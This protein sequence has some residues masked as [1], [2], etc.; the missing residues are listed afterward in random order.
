[1]LMK[2]RPLG[3][4]LR[5]KRN[6]MGVVIGIMAINYGTMAA[7]AGP[8]IDQNGKQALTDMMVSTTEGYWND[9]IAGRVVDWLNTVDPA[10]YGLGLTNTDNGAIEYNGLNYGQLNQWLVSSEASGYDINNINSNGNS[11]QWVFKGGEEFSCDKGGKSVS[12]IPAPG[13]TNAAIIN[14]L[15]EVKKPVIDPVN[16]NPQ[17]NGNLT[18]DDIVS[19][20]TVIQVATVS[21]TFTRPTGYMSREIR[22]FAYQSLRARGVGT[23]SGALGNGTAP[24]T[25]GGS[26]A[27]DYDMD[28]R[29]GTY[30]SGGGSFGSLDPH[31]NAT[32]GQ[33]V[34]NGLDLYNQTATGAVD[35]RFADWAVGGFMFNYTGSQN[36]MALGAGTLNADSYRFMPFASFIPFENAYIDVMAGYGYLNYNQF[37]SNTSANYSSDQ[38]LASVDLGYSIPYEGFEFTGF[39][40]GS[41]IG[42]NVNGYTETNGTRVN[43]YNVSSWTS[44]VG[45]QIVY[46]FD[47]SFGI[48]QPVIRGEWVHGYNDSG[49]VTIIPLGGTSM[50]LPTALGINDWGNLTAGVQTVLPQGVMAFLNYQGQYMNG[51]QNNGVLGGFRLEF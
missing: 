36:I 17:V 13:D 40:G 39:A 42:T 29:I 5:A 18:R 3:L 51:G 33:Q 50:A 38:A 37:N 15:G 32:T 31:Y 26:S 19:L 8:V 14:C 6:I 48:I 1:M 34:R 7:P 20:S 9:A 28:G 49:T 25:G 30:F 2:K 23:S 4:A 35:Y 21:N 10:R 16:P 12:Q 44:T 46:N 24:A 11:Q 27:D 22:R 43:P 47:T 45:S 41:Y